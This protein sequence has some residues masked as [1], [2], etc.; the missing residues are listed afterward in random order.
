MKHILLL[1]IM[2]AGLLM[3]AGAGAQQ[4]ASFS[5]GG[6]TVG[7][8]SRTCN[9]TIEGTLRYNSSTSCVEYCQGTAW[10]CPSSGGGSCGA[11]T[12]SF[13]DQ[14]DVAK[15][16][17]A[18]SNITKINTNSCTGAAVTVS[19]AGTPE[20]RICN[21]S[22]CSS[23]DH[24]WT[25]A[26][27]VIDD[28]QYLQVRVT[29]ANTE[30]TLRTV[31]LSVGGSLELWNV[32][33]AVDGYKIFITST[34]HTG[35][36]G[37]LGQA[38]KICRDRA[39]AAGLNGYYMAW[40]SEST[41]ATG[42]AT[43]FTKPTTIYQRVDGTTVANNWTDLA[44]GTLIA[45]INKDE[46]NVT[47]S[48]FV[49]SGT[50]S[51]GVARAI[52]YTCQDWLSSSITDD[53]TLGTI[54]SATSTWADNGTGALD[55]CGSS[56]RFYCVQQI[57]DP[58]AD[59]KKVFVSSTVQN[60]NM[61]GV[62]AADTICQNLASTAGLSGSFKAW[63]TDGT[64]TNEVVDRFTTSTLPYRMVDGTK[65]ADNW[66]DLIDGAL[67]TGIV[68]N[69]NGTYVSSGRIYSNTTIAG[70]RHT[71]TDHCVNWTSS[72]ITDDSTSGYVGQAGNKWANSGTTDVIDC[73]TNARLI[74][75]EQ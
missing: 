57:A 22:N 4:S 49:W 26:A 17:V 8:D 25:T 14:V 28:D 23:V 32:T 5:D 59:H 11:F 3:A 7:Y 50:T 9:G 46:S 30:S 18:T 73:G 42:P 75:V 1:A 54:A 10:T 27:G 40:L 38:D 74:C 52:T 34:T 6:T 55:D 61:G 15:N 20:Y 43:R 69:E 19:G 36:I 2:G 37:G 60:G 35:A 71:T 39:A 45:G 21:T 12:Y 13:V 47:R 31:T 51:A 66:T 65:V 48:G 24:T 70:L 68:L 63:I 41:A 53:A 72:S 56:F 29:S 33:T 44:D 58:V 62:A 67:K 64:T 16:V